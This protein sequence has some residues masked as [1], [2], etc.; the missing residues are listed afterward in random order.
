M[1]A[2]CAADVQS[3]TEMVRNS[4]GKRDFV[5]SALMKCLRCREVLLNAGRHPHRWKRNVAVKVIENGSWVISSAV[6][7]D[8]FLAW[9]CD[10]AVRFLSAIDVLGNPS[11][12]CYLGG[13]AGKERGI[14]I[15]GSCS[16]AV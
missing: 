1:L 2:V 13:V 4:A 7:A 3:F 12:C 6:W 15:S 5:V 14:L 16:A 9:A 8:M 10:Y 11:R